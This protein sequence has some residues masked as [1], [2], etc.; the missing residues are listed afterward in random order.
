MGVP[1]AQPHDPSPEL[2]LKRSLAEAVSQFE[3]ENFHR[4][5]RRVRV[6]CVD[7]LVLLRLQGVLSPAERSLAESRE[8]QTLMRQLLLREFD[9]LQELLALR[10]NNVFAV[11]R[12]QSLSVDLDPVAD[13]RL[14]IC[15]LDGPVADELAATPRH[16]DAF[17]IDTQPPSD[18]ESD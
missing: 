15:R 11:R 8:G 7:D 18:A 16:E 9:E 2:S 6:H 17:V 14:I 12:V 5:A 13:E 1:S 4:S 3:C 10:L